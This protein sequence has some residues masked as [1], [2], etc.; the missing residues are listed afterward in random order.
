MFTRIRWF[1]YGAAATLGAGAL[2]ITKTRRMRETLDAQGAARASA[3][4]VADGMELVG[5][6]L[7]R[8]AIRLAPDGSN[9][10][11]G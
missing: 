6:R 5:R 7:Q 4:L 10:G 2:V 9:G 11:Y 3:N 8:S 1:V